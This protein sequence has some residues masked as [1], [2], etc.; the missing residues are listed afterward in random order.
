MEPIARVVLVRGLEQG[1]A[2]RHFTKLEARELGVCGSV[3][4]LADGSVEVWAEGTPGAVEG[5]IA[6]LRHGPPSARV[7]HV[8]V[9]N[10]EPQGLV[11]FEVQ[12]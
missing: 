4:N 2:F 11:R 8:D 6:W 12:R 7:E 5:L 10:A 3:R 1:V 9:R